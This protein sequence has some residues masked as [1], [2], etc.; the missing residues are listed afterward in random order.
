MSWKTQ[1]AR[2]PDLEGLEVNSPMGY[3]GD[4]IYPTEHKAEKSGT[5]YYAPKQSEVAAQSGRDPKTGEITRSFVATANTTYNASE[6]I[7]R[8]SITAEDVGN[9]GGIEK[10]D[11]AGGRMALLAILEKLE[12]YKAEKLFTGTKHSVGKDL[13]KSLRDGLKAVKRYSGRLALVCSLE[14]YNTII[15]SEAFYQRL[16][17]TGVTLRNREDVLS[18]KPEVLREML[19]QFFA[20]EEIL[21]GDDEIWN[22]EAYK[23]LAAIVRLPSVEELSYKYKPELGKTMCYMMEDSGKDFA[24]ESSCSEKDRINDYDGISYSDVVE[25]NSGAKYIISGIVEGFDTATPEA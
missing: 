13:F 19:Q 10:G 20:V 25:F 8:R 21:V 18:L 6:K 1:N 23:G 15:Q 24:V 4:K 2:R 14:V 7:A 17:F 22:I 16:S 3:I 9:L 5:L 11:L 12:A